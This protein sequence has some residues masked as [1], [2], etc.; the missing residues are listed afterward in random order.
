MPFSCVRRAACVAGVLVVSS[1]VL[2]SSVV[3]A[4]AQSRNSGT[5]LTLTRSSTFLFVAVPASVT[6]NG[7]DAASLYRGETATINIAPGQN[8]VNVSGFGQ[9]GSWTLVVNAKPGGHYAIEVEP[10]G[11]SIPPAA[12]LGLPGAL[13]DTAINKNSGA[14]KMRLVSR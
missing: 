13:L 9:P 1:F 12:L 14:F 6:V 3:A 7:R 5:R 11:E 10:R 2:W 8:T 4:P